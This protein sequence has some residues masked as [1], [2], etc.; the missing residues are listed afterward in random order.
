MLVVDRRRRVLGDLLMKLTWILRLVAAAL[1]AAVLVPAFRRCRNA[2]LIGISALLGAGIVVAMPPAP[3][4][5]TPVNDETSFRT[6][7]ADATETQI[8]LA[9]DI[10]L[11]SCAD[12][13]ADRNSATALVINGAGFSITQACPNEHVLEQAA[14]GA[15]TLNNVT[16]AGVSGGEG[17]STSGD[18]SMTSAAITD[19]GISASGGVSISGSIITDSAFDGI[20]ANGSLSLVNS[21]ISG[22]TDNGISGGTAVSLTAGSS[23]TNSGL[24]AISTSADVSLTDSSISTSGGDGI[25]T[26]ST[27][28]GAVVLMGSSINDSAG[29]SVNAV[30]GVSL[31]GSTIGM[32]VI[33][34]SDDV[35]LTDSALTD[36]GIS[37][38]GDVPLTRSRLTNSFISASGDV[39]LTDSAI[40]DSNFD[41]ISANGS[42]SLVNSTIS[43]SNDAGISGGSDVSL[44]NSTITGSGLD[45]IVTSGPVS[46]VYATVVH[47]GQDNVDHDGT[48]TSFGSVV[49][50][51]GGGF[52]NCAGAGSTSSQGFNWDDDGSCGFGQSSDHSNAGDPELGL[53]ADNGGPTQTHLPDSGSPLIG[54]IPSGSCQAN[55]AAGITTDQ[56]GLARP[57]PP[58][59]SCDI[60]AVEVA[61]PAPASPT[62]PASPAC[63]AA[64]SSVVGGGLAG[65]EGVVAG[66]PLGIQLF[67]RRRR[68]DRRRHRE[69]RA[70]DRARALVTWLMV[71]GIGVAVLAAC[72]PVKKA[73]PIC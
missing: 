18:V 12:G 66:A 35:S 58:G 28:A 56:R 44:T 50:F 63:P 19:S 15:L 23:I 30:G 62:S 39:S 65:A 43:G 34:T 4:G 22:S 31:T 72:Q 17:V 45:G 24:D 5:A 51:F 59:G 10:T 11:A 48:L 33:S 69:L 40:T 60:G 2:A 53:L 16:L 57:S 67:L 7:F 25:D 71:A 29:D 55:G 64:Q 27:N 38:G 42:L 46:L 20:S 13:D 1:A 61:A 21:T 37:A 73:P 49:A 26:D 41:G 8:D 70:R 47:S 32:G 68:S 54:V 36:S 52:A 6:A 3:A 14:A 9:A